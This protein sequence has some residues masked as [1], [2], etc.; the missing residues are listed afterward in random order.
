M[1]TGIHLPKLPRP[2]LLDDLYVVESQLGRVDG[3]VEVLDLVEYV[4][5][6]FDK[7]DGATAVSFYPMIQRLSL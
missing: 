1:D 4:V 5:A 3:R 7:K 2:D 6:R